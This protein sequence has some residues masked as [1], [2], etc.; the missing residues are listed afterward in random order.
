ME[1]A[2][3][4]PRARVVALDLGDRHLLGVVHAVLEDDLLVDDAYL[5]RVSH[6]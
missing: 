5:R 6:R 3:R 1:L 2:R 4:V